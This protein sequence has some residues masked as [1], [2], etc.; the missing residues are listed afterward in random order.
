MKNLKNSLVELGLSEFDAQ[1][2][3][4]LLKRGEA[5]VGELVK[6]LNAHRE[7]IYG[8][9]RRLSAEDLVTEKE[10]KKIK[11]FQ[12]EEPDV[13][14]NKT[15]EKAE[16]AGSILP[17]LKK[18]YQR[19]DVSVQVLE[20]PEGYE[21]LQQDIQKTLK[22][23]DDY[24][25]IGG[26]G[27]SWFDVVKDFYMKYRRKSLKRGIHLKSLSFP[28]EAKGIIEHE[29]PG[30]CEVRVLPENFQAP[31]STKIYGDRVAIQA[32]GERPFVI[33]IKS[34]AVSIAY[35]KYFQSLWKVAEEV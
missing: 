24:Y 33:L 15:Q 13:L 11:Y 5:P 23:G 21:Q 27:G 26:S 7:L 32:F 4:A 2:Y 30:F 19:P 34:K 1:V 14:V 12:A 8:A 20:G 9:M 3:L 10:K 17:D 25:V 28:N 22:D 31:S 29:P 35:R 18:L 6:E 16:L